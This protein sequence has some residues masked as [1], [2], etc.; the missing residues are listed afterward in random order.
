MQQ[1]KMIIRSKPHPRKIIHEGKASTVIVF[2]CT[3]PDI[4]VKG[5]RKDLVQMKLTV[6]SLAAWTMFKDNNLYVGKYLYIKGTPAT[7]LGENAFWASD[8]EEVKFMLPQQDLFD[9]E[10]QKF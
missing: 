1:F 10:E 3:S 6:Y 9:F 8:L 2:D 7:A 5:K 4:K